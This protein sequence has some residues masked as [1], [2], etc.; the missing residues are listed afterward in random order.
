MLPCFDV[1]I[2]FGGVS[3]KTTKGARARAD[4]EG[5]PTTVTSIGSC[6]LK[7]DLKSEATHC[8]PC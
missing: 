1:T 7:L 6:S 8:T 4:V 5:A 2:L 3:K